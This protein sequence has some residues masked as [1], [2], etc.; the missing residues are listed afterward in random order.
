MFQ[1][2]LHR[3]RKRS[4]I[5]QRSILQRPKQQKHSEQEDQ[6]GAVA[7]R[8]NAPAGL[9]MARIRHRLQRLGGVGD[10]GRNLRITCTISSCC[11]SVSVL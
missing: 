5:D 6:Q 2:P 4:I 8:A 10:Q 9:D 11:D 1:E 7:Y 3:P